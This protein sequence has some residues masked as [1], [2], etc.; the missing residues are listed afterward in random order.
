[1][2]LKGMILYEDKE[3]LVVNKPAGLLVH[4]AGK[5]KEKTLVD[6]LL[7]K[8]PEIKNVGD[9]S[10]GGL[11]RPGIVHRLDKETSG[12]LIVA[13]TQ[14][15]FDFLKK[16]FQDR[17]IKK[18]YLA[19]V[20][21]KIKR[22]R[23][24]ID[25]PIGRSRN[26]ARRRLSGHRADGK[27]REALTEYKVLK[28]GEKMTLLEVYPRTGR[29]HQIRVHLAGIGH[30]VVGDK[31]YAPQRKDFS[32]LALHAVSIKLKNLTGKEIKIEAPIP[33][34]LKKVFRIA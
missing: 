25:S 15:A 20:W 12:V 6:F 5:S 2:N 7:K 32:R 17:S 10:A 19:L 14:R 28:R 26:D 18:K 11:T 3:I 16:Q 13:K 27:L 29:T 8:Y 22:E 4:P 1:M 23:G 24:M 21:G 33:S 30:P 9:P 31:L 34:D